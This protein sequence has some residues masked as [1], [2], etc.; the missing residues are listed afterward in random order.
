MGY[1]K[2]HLGHNYVI[3]NE[4]MSRDLPVFVLFVKTRGSCPFFNN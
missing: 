4:V 1:I 2:T 3:Y